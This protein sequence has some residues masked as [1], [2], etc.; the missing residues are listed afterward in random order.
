MKGDPLLRSAYSLMV[1]AAI[2]AGL[3]IPFWVIAARLYDPVAL[4]RG[5]ALI[6]VMLELSAICQLNMANAITRFLPSLARGT[7]RAL[8]SA[9][10]LS[11]AAALL[12]GVAFV[13]VAPRISHEFASL[14][15]DWRLGAL[16]IA[17]L[18]GWGWFALQDAALTALRRAPW[19][20]VE[21]GVFGVL[22]LVGLP[23]FLALGAA[24]GVFL[25]WTVPAL[26][27]I[28]PVN[29]FL[30][31]TAIPEHLR[32]NRP[33]GSAVLARLGRRGLVRFMGQDWG[34]TVLAMAPTAIL[35]VLIVALLGSSANAY[36]FIP[37]MMISTFNL[38]FIAA[39]TSLVAEGA[40][41]ED[42]IRALAAR[43]AQRFG[44]VLAAGTAV[45]VAAAPLILSPFGADYV[46]ES[47]T[48]L[49]L[50]ACGCAFYAVIVL[51][52]AIA[53]LEGRTANILAAE[54]AKVPLLLGG[55]LLLSDPLGIEGVALAWLGS[56]AVVA[57]AV[58]P[59]L[60]RFFRGRPARAARPRPVRV[61]SL[62][63]LG[64]LLVTGAA[65]CSSQASQESGAPA[66][67]GVG[68][69]VWSDEFSGPRGSLPNSRK[70]TIET[71]YGWGDGELQSYTRRPANVSLD[72]R[73]HLEITARRQRFTGR[74]GRTANYTSARINTRAKLEFAYG[75]VEARIR[76]PRGRGLLP[77]FWALGA[78]LEVVGWPRAGEIDVVEVYDREP[79][80]V[81][82][83]LHGPRRG[84]RDYALESTR[85]AGAPLA[86][87]FHVYGIS[88]APGRI[89]FRFDGEVYA[90]RTRSDLPPGSRWSFE[91][92]FFLLFT[93]A[94]GPRWLG[95]PDS[96]TPWPATML[97]DWVR[98]RRGPATFC[99]V[100]RSPKL[101]PRC[102]REDRR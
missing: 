90:V 85:P 59:S 100:V 80:T 98:V 76:V 86:S 96:T 88:W 94:V 56:V 10:A 27:L 21:N 47:T 45:M 71:G 77:A 74:D 29:L 23:A 58:T 48:V 72:G 19:V 18:V 101:R 37:Y 69:I 66:R 73:G 53:R 89:V 92:P 51:Y 65:R 24:N 102:P 39:S 8:L 57:L 7:A 67:G 38:L 68:S 84:H 26:L 78:N 5:A 52:V 62:L 61:T 83:T 91:R 44:L 12:A 13:L 46:R 28:V 93:L 97:V 99:P 30:L 55:V 33:A 42:R 34:A 3:G 9:Y 17:G 95:P 32:R 4:G 64:A 75:R 63:L 15:G 41:A 70:W 1:N 60:V 36:F 54:A 50:L 6:A 81:H 43:I 87:G 82:G 25:A 40:L 31:R 11:G 20:P 79:S 2:T 14:S 16:Y 22:K 35:P 49:R